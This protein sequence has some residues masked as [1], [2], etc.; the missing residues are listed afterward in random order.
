MD[1]GPDKYEIKFKHI[2]I[3]LSTFQ[4]VYPELNFSKQVLAG[5]NCFQTISNQFCSIQTSVK[6]FKL[7]HPSFIWYGMVQTDMNL[8]QLFQLVYPV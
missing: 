2:T 3:R 8:L 7:L 1:M 6:W 5:F 4:L